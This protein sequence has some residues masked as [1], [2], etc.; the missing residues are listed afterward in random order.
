M[1]QF[2]I[3]VTILVSVPDDNSL[4]M[5]ADQWAAEIGSQYANLALTHK[6]IGAEDIQ[7]L[8]VRESTNEQPH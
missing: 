1:K 5:N 7:E 2:E 6:S 3:T 8:T 4:G